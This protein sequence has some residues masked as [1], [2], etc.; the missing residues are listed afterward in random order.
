MRMV[1]AMRITEH[2]HQASW[3][4]DMDAPADWS[5]SVLRRPRLSPGAVSTLPEVPAA[6]LWQAD[7]ASAWA[8]V[9]G[10]LE[11]ATVVWRCTEDHS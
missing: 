5:T 9:R 3:P 8:T 1:S 11:T 10:A 7:G 6:P 2:W 4:V